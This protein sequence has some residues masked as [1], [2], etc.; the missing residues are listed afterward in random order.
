MQQSPFNSSDHLFA[1]I[2]RGEYTV[3]AM[4]RIVH[5]IQ[6]AH[7]QTTEAAPLPEDY[8]R[9]LK[10][11]KMPAIDQQTLTRLALCCKPTPGDN[12]VGYVTLGR[13]ITVHRKDCNNI[14]RLSDDERARLIEINWADHFGSHYPVDMVISADDTNHA[15]REVTQLLSIEKITIISMQCFRVK[16][17]FGLTIRLTLEVQDQYHADRIMQKMYGL[18]HIHAVEKG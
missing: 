14:H 9:L 16:N 18:S 4:L 11:S 8:E 3:Q 2:A 15:V 12:I 6:A 13:G 17:A 10:A 7:T 5:T 1:A